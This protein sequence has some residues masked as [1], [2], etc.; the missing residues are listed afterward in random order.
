MN[1][2]ET[3]VNEE[4]VNIDEEEKVSLELSI[5]EKFVEPLHFGDL[6]ELVGLS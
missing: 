5:A 1:G 4:N 6:L 3:Y 2:K